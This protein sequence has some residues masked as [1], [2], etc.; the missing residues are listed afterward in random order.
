MVRACKLVMKIMNHYRQRGCPVWFLA[1]NVDLSGVEDIIVSD[2]LGG[3][4][5][6]IFD[7]QRCSPTWRKRSYWLNYPVKQLYELASPVDD[8]IDPSS[9]LEEGWHN[10][11]KYHSPC[12]TLMASQGRIDDKRMTVFMKRGSRWVARSL[13]VNEREKM[14][15]FPVDYVRAPG[16]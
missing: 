3:L 15:G 10:G 14:M 16:T 9:C 4:P 5:R 7:A 12:N 6:L 11:W 1:E 13:S 2:I 8:P